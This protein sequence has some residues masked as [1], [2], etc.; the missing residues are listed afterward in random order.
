MSP[1][2]TEKLIER[3]YA[4]FNAGE[5]DGMVACVGPAFVHDVNQGERRKGK[6]KFREFSEHMTVCY[7]E[8]LRDIVVMVSRDGTRASAEFVVH[9]QYIGTDAGLPK[10][11]GQRYKL[12]A[13]AFFAV[14]DGLITRVST[15][16]NV[17]NWLAQVKGE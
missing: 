11:R 5:L 7:R 15:T 13:G 8:E 16:Y 4:A 2:E 10:A 6:L 12:P 17:A 3:Y 1:K 9:G 14:K